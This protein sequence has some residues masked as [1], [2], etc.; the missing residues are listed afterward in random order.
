V[1]GTVRR[2]FAARHA[3]DRN[4]RPLNESNNLTDRHLAG[5][6]G[7]KITAHRSAP[8]FDKAGVPQLVKNYLQEPERYCLSLRD[9]ADFNRTLPISPG[10][11]KDCTDCVLAL[12]GHHSFLLQNSFC[13]RLPAPAGDI[14]G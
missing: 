2:S 1:K 11:F 14:I 5:L 9:F 12:L 3:C 7:E 10:E 6:S 4:N 13:G 8:G